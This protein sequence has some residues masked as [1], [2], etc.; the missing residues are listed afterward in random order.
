MRLFLLSRLFDNKRKQMR[1]K[2][3]GKESRKVQNALSKL[4]LSTLFICIISLA[5]QA[6]C[7]ASNVALKWD[8]NT[9][10]DLAGY[11][12]YYSVDSP[13]SPF[14]GTGAIEGASPVDLHSQTFG[15]ISG[16]DPGRNYYFAVTAYNTS[17]LESSFSNIVSVPE[18]LPPTISISYPA[19][20]AIVS[21]TVSVTASAA[22]NLGVVKVEFY[23]NG[24]LH[25][26]DSTGHYL[27]SW[28]TS[29]LAVGTYTLMAKA[30]DDAGNVGQSGNVSVMVIKDTT[31]P[32]VSIT[33]PAK[34]STVSGTV[35]LTATASDNVGVSMLEVYDN[36]VLM[37]ATNV[38]PYSYSWNTTTVAN[39]THNL[40]AK[41]YD[42]S[43]NVGKSGNIILTVA[44]GATGGPAK[45]N[46]NGKVSYHQT[47]SS[48]Y[49]AIVN[50]ANV[51]ISVQA[52][53]FT[54]SVNFNRNI[55]V[56][57]VGGYD[58]SFTTH[59]GITTLKGCLTL[60][61]GLDSIEG[62]SIL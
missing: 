29:S 38:A 40:F 41:A 43:G 12:I 10:A 48:A 3:M 24:N 17:G 46:D 16:L 14:N 5:G 11:K 60:G 32:T 33:G 61:T 15:T 8:P 20:N 45:L 13:S 49:N 50:G 7:F 27:F 39:G 51:I 23:V 28:D 47:L 22:D 21:A 34:N 37:T 56:K 55:P 58:P 57:L 31:P 6:P 30:Y 18:S 36:N 42:T 26:T 19:N 52:L 25:T 54:E 53:T 4:F 35:S 44:N 62:I 9:D 2:N 1:K 59:T